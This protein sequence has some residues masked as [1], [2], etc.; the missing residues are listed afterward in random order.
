MGRLRMDG[1]EAWGW[2]PEHFPDGKRHPADIVLLAFVLNVIDVLKDRDSALINAYLLANVALVIGVRNTIIAKSKEHYLDGYY[3]N[4]KNT[5]QKPFSN[6][7]L[8]R[9]VEKILSCNCHIA[10]PGI[11]Y[12]FKNNDT[13]REYLDRISI[14]L[15]RAASH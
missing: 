6:Q 5:F 10:G 8:A 11:A 12:V 9:Y 2:D 14:N 13:E 15:K 7:E 4:S 3:I 1:Y